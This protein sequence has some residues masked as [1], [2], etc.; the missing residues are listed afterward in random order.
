MAKWTKERNEELRTLY[1]SMTAPELAEYFGTSVQAVYVQAHKI[2]LNKHQPNKITLTH[3]QES[4]MR[5]NF[6]HMSNKICALILGIS[7]R[8]VVRQA[9]RL[10]LEKTAQFMCECQAHTSKKARESHLKKGTYPAKGYYSPNLQRGDK[11]QFGK[12]AWKR[13][14]KSA[15]S[16]AKNLRNTETTP[17]P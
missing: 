17:T 11:Y 10:G 15:A 14:K 13:T 4:W 6:P 12:R 16:A 2:G 1:E 3:E 5:R 8:S 7:P 9:R